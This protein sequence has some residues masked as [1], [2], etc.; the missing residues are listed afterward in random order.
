GD[1]LIDYLLTGFDIAYVVAGTDL[2]GVAGKP[3]GSA[4]DD[5]PPAPGRELL[6]DRRSADGLNLTDPAFRFGD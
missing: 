6:V 3:L 1:G 5:A 4:D 2:H